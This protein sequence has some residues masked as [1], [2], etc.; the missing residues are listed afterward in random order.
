V[1]QSGR[2][3]TGLDLHFGVTPTPSP[4]GGFDGSDNGLCS[5]MNV[6]VLD[7]DPL[8]RRARSIESATVIHEKQTLSAVTAATGDGDG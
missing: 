4:G 7:N 8:V 1:R 2:R 5:R 6:D 3:S